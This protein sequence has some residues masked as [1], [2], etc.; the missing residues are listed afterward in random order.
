MLLLTSISSLAVL[1]IEHT[2]IVR[3]ARA[4]LGNPSFVDPDVNCGERSSWGRH[5]T[6][7]MIISCR[8]E[9]TAKLTRKLTKPQVLL[10][11]L[12]EIRP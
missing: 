5:L 12:K 9:N 7:L 2:A 3:Q 8:S 11:L 6:V 4:N 1:L 10:L